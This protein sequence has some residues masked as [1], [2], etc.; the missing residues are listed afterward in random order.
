MCTYQLY[1]PHRWTTAAVTGGPSLQSGVVDTETLSSRILDAGQKYLTT[2]GMTNCAVCLPSLPK[3]KYLLKT[4]QTSQP[5]L[6]LTVKSRPTR[7]LV[8]G[9]QKHRRRKLRFLIPGGA[10]L[11]RSW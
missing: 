2:H 10:L 8:H 11:R 6:Q 7:G 3:A 5:I 9:C 1:I 4:D